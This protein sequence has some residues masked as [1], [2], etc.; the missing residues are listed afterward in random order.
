MR[1]NDGLMGGKHPGGPSTHAD[2]VGRCLACRTGHLQ[3]AQLSSYGTRQKA[4]AKKAAA[5]EPRL[6]D[7]PQPHASSLLREPVKHLVLARHRRDGARTLN[8]ARCG[9]T[10]K[11]SRRE[12][13]LA[14]KGRQVAGRA[15]L[16]F[17]DKPIK[18]R[19]PEGIACAGRIARLARARWHK[20]VLGSR[21]NE[22][23]LGPQRHGSE[24]STLVENVLGSGL[25]V[26]C[27][28]QQQS[29]VFVD[30]HQVS[31]R[32]KRRHLLDGFM[33][34]RPQAGPVVRVITD[35]DTC[36]AATLTA[37]NVAVRA[38]SSVRE[39][40]PTWST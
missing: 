30:F 36:L 1:Q 40:D 8:A 6:I 25:G 35:E 37:C 18:K 3:T 4:R 19:A 13:L 7:V 9:R 39:R 29:L 24:G 2:G 5:I 34:A 10:G 32:Q 21:R 26:A 38:G 22:C 12:K 27:T 20:H 23:P 28:A 11:G 31:P 16:P 33:L 15:H 17:M 14:R